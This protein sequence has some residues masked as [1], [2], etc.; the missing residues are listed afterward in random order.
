[1][2]DDFET[3]VTRRIWSDPEFAKAVQ[4]SPAE[5]LAQL[6]VTVPAGVKVEVV[7]QQPDTLYFAIPPARQTPE[8]QEFRQTQMDIW[9]SG[10][11]F[12]WM[13]SASQAF[14]MLAIRSSV[15]NEPKE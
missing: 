3:M 15:R 14:N 1:M 2:A 12:I 13:N 4:E 11:S 8:S 9:S 6:G 5:A 7:V 10:D